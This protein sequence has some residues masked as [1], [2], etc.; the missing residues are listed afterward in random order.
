MLTINSA[1]F[2]N[3]IIW[4]YDTFGV[5]VKSGD[6]WEFSGELKEYREDVSFH[7]NMIDSKRIQESILKDHYDFLTEE[8]K[9]S[10]YKT[11]YSY[12]DSIDNKHLRTIMSN[13]MQE[14]DEYDILNAIG[15]VSHHHCYRG[16]Y[17]DH[18]VEML[19]IADAVIVSAFHNKV[20]RDVVIAGIV[21]HDV[22]KLFTYSIKSGDTPKRTFMDLSFGHISLSYDMFNVVVYKYTASPEYPNSEELDGLVRHVKHIILSHHGTREWG[23]AVEPCSI[24]ANLVHMVDMM[25]SKMNITVLSSG[26][27]ATHPNQKFEDFGFIAGHDG[28]NAALQLAKD[29]RYYNHDRFVTLSRCGLLNR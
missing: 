6:I 19:K 14:F 27:S 8:Q 15:S 10:L 7:V 3:A 12:I 18:I 1:N 5:S 28:P 13:L 16:G 26:G 11:L 4:N 21:A 17:L 29:S 2:K 23:S 20:Q 22:G 9:L 25:S 24:E